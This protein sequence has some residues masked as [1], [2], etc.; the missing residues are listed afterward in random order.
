MSQ[1]AQRY[2]A[3]LFQTGV[4]EQQLRQSASLILE[5]PA[6]YQA[7]VSPAVRLKEKQ[8]VIH[9]LPFA[10]CPKQLLHFYELLAE[11]GRFCILSEIVHQFHLLQLASENKAVCLLR[12]AHAPSQET[13]SQLGRA[14]C[15]LHKLAAVEMQ[16]CIEP[17]LLGGFVLEINGTTYNKSVSG[18]LQ[19]LS[20]QLQ[21][22]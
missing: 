15:Q 7:L 12:C 6:L 4:S 18:Q 21:E 10:D 5:N 11:K 19:R 22:R 16:V 2:A 8:A 17:A 3:A 1:T 9:R 14:M 20:R 13:V